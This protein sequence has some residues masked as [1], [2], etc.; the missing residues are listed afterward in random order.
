MEEV[1]GVQPQDTKTSKHACIGTLRR[2]WLGRGH[3]T[4]DHTHLDGLYTSLNAQPSYF[5]CVFMSCGTFKS[6]PSQFL[7]FCW[8]GIFCVTTHH[9]RGPH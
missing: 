9:I 3:V 6:L 4:K 7:H 1:N 2:A 5:L 8:Y